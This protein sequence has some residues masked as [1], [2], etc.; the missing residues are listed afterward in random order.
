MSPNL[1]D[2][3]LRR[4]LFLG[5]ISAPVNRNRRRRLLARIRHS[6]ACDRLRCHLQLHEFE[7]LVFLAGLLTLGI[8]AAGSFIS[9]L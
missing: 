3:E 2:S 8:L 4:R 9:T 7:C 1:H 5:L 6:E